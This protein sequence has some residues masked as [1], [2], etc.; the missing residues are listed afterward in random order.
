MNKYADYMV[1]GAQRAGSTWLYNN[2]VCHPAIVKAMGAY[3]TEPAWRQKEITYFSRDINYQPLEYYAARFTGRGEGQ[4]CGDHT[5]LTY[6]LTE[7]KV[8]LIKEIMPEAKIIFIMRNPIFRAWSHL[9]MHAFVLKNIDLADNMEC[10]RFLTENYILGCYSVALSIWEKYFPDM[11]TIEYSDIA[12][13]P[14]GVLESVFNHIGVALPE[15]WDRYPIDSQPNLTSRDAIPM[16]Y[17]RLLI[18]LFE[19]ELRAMALRHPD[20]ALRWRQD[21][22]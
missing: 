19:G 12:V 8:S 3:P 9:K 7:D 17:H 5:P 10:Y 20:I 6:A 16:K 18:N 15:S 11:L 1:I 21:A 2:M 13:N 4:L 22:C 14:R